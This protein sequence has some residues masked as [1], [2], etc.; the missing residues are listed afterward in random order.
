MKIV[1]CN[2]VFRIFLQNTTVQTEISNFGRKMG[3]MGGAIS[4]LTFFRTRVS[5]TLLISPVSDLT[6][7]PNP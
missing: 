6:H 3:Q 5:F 4:P 7:E 1:D 2:V